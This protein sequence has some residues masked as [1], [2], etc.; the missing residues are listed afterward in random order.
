MGRLRKRHSWPPLSR[1]DLPSSSDLDTDPFSFFISNEAST[2]Q[3]Q[4]YH[5]P[6]AF[7][8]K[9]RT[10]SMPG[11]HRRDSSCRRLSA[12]RQSPVRALM[13]WIER[14][15]KQYFHY[16]RDSPRLSGD[17]PQNS[18]VEPLIITI[19][20]APPTTEGSRSPQASAGTV[21]SPPLRGRGNVRYGSGNR[22]SKNIKTPP[23]RPRVWREPSSDIWSIQEEGGINEDGTG[24]GIS[25]AG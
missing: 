5:F 2:C 18:P 4:N 25:N 9:R 16:P 17:V 22:V 24:L 11:L 10:R 3:T 1:S 21:S 13:R 8:T 7:S 6:S 19:T 20:P 12:V 15:E 23:R 14:M